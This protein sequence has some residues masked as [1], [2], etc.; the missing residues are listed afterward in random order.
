MQ[1]GVPDV[2]KPPF[3]GPANHVRQVF[4]RLAE[5]GHSL[6]LIAMFDG[7]IWRS[8]DLEL[9]DPVYIPES[10]RGLFRLLERAARRAQFELRLPYAAFFESLRFAKVCRKELQG[11]DLLYERMGWVGYGGGLAAKTM[12]IPLVM[13]VNGDHLSEFEMLGVAPKGLQRVLSINM[14]K[15]AIKL[16][17]HFI[18]CGDGWRERLIER[19]SID[20]AR[21]ATIENGSSVLEFL[22]RDQLRCFHEGEYADSEAATTLAFIG[23]FQ[24]WQGVEVM[25]RSFAQAIR[26]GA[27]LKLYLI[28]SAPVPLEIKQL[29]DDLN[30]NGSVTFKDQLTAYELALVVAKADIGIS[31]YCGRAEFSG[32]KVFDYKAAGLATIASGKNGY[33]AS[34]VHGRT[35]WIVPPCD[36][37]ALCEAIIRLA[38]DGQLRKE[39]GRNARIEAEESHG[40]KHTAAGLEQVF[41]SVVSQ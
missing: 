38:N 31:P 18:A 29:A 15:L 37:N 7:G 26:R 39:I 40:W 19:W 25:L 11:Y 21:V 1:A 30:V 14:M 32:L 13:E 10:D 8:D 34:L 6:R 2:R 36:E 23:G 4:S 33:P 20:P 22:E 3:S 12:R 35:G 41:E 24:P 9:Y 16:A 27:R 17:S 28:G 5:R